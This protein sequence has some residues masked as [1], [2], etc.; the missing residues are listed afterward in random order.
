M[1]YVLIKKKNKKETFY[2]KNRP[3]VLTMEKMEKDRFLSCILLCRMTSADFLEFHLKILI[4]VF[5]FL[6]SFHT[7]ES[8]VLPIAV[9]LP[10]C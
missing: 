3:A 7:L 8:F 10:N 9:L 5:V 2:L 6:P 1:K 4:Q